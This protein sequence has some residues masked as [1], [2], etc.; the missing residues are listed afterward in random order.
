M[1][2]LGW[3]CDIPRL[4]KISGW[5]IA[6]LIRVQSGDTVPVTHATNNNSSLGFAVQRPNRISDPNQFD[7]RTVARYFNTAAFA[8][9]SQFVI[10]SSSRNPVRGPG[11]QNADLMIGK[12]F[13]ITERMNFEIRAEAFNV[14]NTPP[15][16]DP[17]G[18][19]CS[20][21]FGTITSAGN[22]RDF[23]FVVKAHF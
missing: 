13:R 19:F 23:E 6:G 7:G 5:Q 8:A 14:S 10:G 20:G 17:N 2:A 4:W 16:N 3:V 11:L 22:P 18:S 12:T 15:L 9:A 21:A 1:F